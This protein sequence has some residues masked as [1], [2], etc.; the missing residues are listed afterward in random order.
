MQL[1]CLEKIFNFLLYITKHFLYF[2]KLKNTL[3]FP[4][5]WIIQNSPTVEIWRNNKDMIKKKN[6]I[7]NCD[8]SRAK[9]FINN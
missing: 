3:I 5:P 8:I 2:V 9:V 1:V 7:N 4:R 6:L